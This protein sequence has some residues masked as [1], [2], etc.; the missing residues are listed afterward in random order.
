MVLVLGHYADRIEATLNWPYSSQ[1]IRVRNPDPESSQGAS[2]RL[3]LQALPSDRDAVLVVLADQPLINAQDI[4]ELIQ[5]YKDRCAGVQMVQPM[6]DG[7][8]GNPVIFS[9][10]VRAHMLAASSP[11]GGQQWRMAHPDQVHLWSS[12]NSHYRLDVDTPG[13]M[14]ALAALGYPLSW[15]TAD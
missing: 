7:Q 5:A 2:L 11:V 3:G 9:A 13:D 14:A 1:W 12:D 8:P 10:E 4:S 6:V 15:P